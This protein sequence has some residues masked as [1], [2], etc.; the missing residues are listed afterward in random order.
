MD[1]FC[2][3]KAGH[4]ESKA[5]QHSRNDRCDSCWFS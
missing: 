1:V 2:E 5:G 4:S 3:A